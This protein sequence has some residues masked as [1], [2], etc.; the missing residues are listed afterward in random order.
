MLGKEPSSDAA[1]TSDLLFR[2]CQSVYVSLKSGY[3]EC[4]VS[5]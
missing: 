2:S 3:Q 5:F 1:D 4:K